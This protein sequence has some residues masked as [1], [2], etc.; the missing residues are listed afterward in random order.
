MH[1]LLEARP[2]E[3]GGFVF[4]YGRDQRLPF[5]GWAEQVDGVTAT[6]RPRDASGVSTYAMPYTQAAIGSNKDRVQLVWPVPVLGDVAVT[7][8]SDV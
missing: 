6:S 2:T 7:M 5:G 1:R 3:D 4:T 8:R